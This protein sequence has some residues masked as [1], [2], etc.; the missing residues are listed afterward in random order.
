LNALEI[1]VRLL[2]ALGALACGL[3]AGAVVI[4]LLA[5]TL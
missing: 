3:V 1:W 4:K 2:A 5:N